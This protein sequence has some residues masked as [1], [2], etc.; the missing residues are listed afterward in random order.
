VLVLTLGLTLALL[1]PAGAEP[2]I[3]PDST[4][5]E[6]WTLA[7][8]LRV[9][10]RHIPF[11]STVAMA[12]AF[13]AGSA[14]DGAGREGLS[15]L[16]AESWYTG[17]AG[18]IPER[19]REELASQ[20]PMGW[21]IK[22]LP[23]WTVFI[24]GSTPRQYPVLLQQMAVRL[25]GVRVPAATL[26]EATRRVRE[27]LRGGYA[28]HPEDVA[29]LV[30]R[31]LAAGADSTALARLADGAGLDGV[32]PRDIERTLRERF[33]PSNA[34]L[35]I[36]GDLL[37]LDLRAFLEREFGAIPGGTARA[38]DSIVTRPAGM[39]LRIPGL[40]AAAGVV[41]VL[42]PS[43]TDADH[44]EFFVS[45][46]LMGSRSL[47]QWGPQV[48]PLASRF[49]FSLFDDP[50]LARF[51]PPTDPVLA[52][53][54]WVAARLDEMLDPVSRSVM[55]AEGIDAVKRG[56]FWMLGGAMM[57][58]LLAGARSQP[59]M[60]ASL[61]STMAVR[62]VWQPESFWAGYRERFAM[63]RELPIETWTGWAMDP[64]HQVRLV[65]R[66]GASR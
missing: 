19:T 43:L 39:T 48:L 3:L 1:R 4:F 14:A 29:A 44:P 10:L 18:E 58:D 12:I 37:G 61:A 28:T 8:G 38:R 35:S 40:S 20:R 59:G 53:P 49:R 55:P 15:W 25:R 41:G 66:G 6:Q 52:S 50:D 47:G 62:A 32:A 51:Y 36:A 54:S 31:A 2:S 33:V 24:E 63:V 16:L 42:T 65:L 17:A 30:P 7:N 22:V 5:V 60:V 26:Q 57:P 23:R 45:V 13:D 21:Q 64:A 11:S 9:S 46:L 34:A 27:D 56:V